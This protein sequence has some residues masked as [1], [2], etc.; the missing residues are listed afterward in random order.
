MRL[1]CFSSLNPKPSGISDYSEALLPH[2]ATR[3]STLDLFIEDYEPSAQFAC[4]NVRIRPWQEFEPEHRAG[5]YDAVLYHIG[6]NPFHVYIYDLAM[7]IPGVLVLH[8]FNLHYLVANAT[9]TRDDWEAYLREVEHSAGHAALERAREARAADLPLDY[10]TVALNRSLVERSQGAIVHSE[11]MVALLRGAG[12]HLPVRRIPHGVDIPSVDAAVARRCLAQRTGWSLDEKTSVIGIFGFLKPYKRIHESL[13]AFSR[14]RQHSPHI[15]MVLVGEEHPDYPLR[16]LIVDLKLDNDVRILGHVPI[17]EF[18]THMAA[19]D[20]CINLRRPTAGETS[21]SLLRALSLGKPTLISEIGSFL[22][23]PDGAAIRI[24]VDG[25]EESWIYEYLSVLLQDPELAQGI[26]ANGKAYVEQNCQWPKVAD[27]YVSFLDGCTRQSA[28]AGTANVGRENGFQTSARALPSA[29]DLAEYVVGFSHGSTLMEDYVLQHVKRLVRTLQVTPP[30]GP[31]DAVL[32]LGSYLQIT[33]GLKKYLGYGEVRGGYY[34]KIGEQK[35]RSTTSITGEEFT[36]PTDFFDCERDR[37][38]YPD[39][40]FKTVLCCELLEHLANDPMHMMAEINRIL[41]LGGW[42]V[43]TTPNITGFR[44]VYAVLRGYHPGL[45]PAYVKPSLDGSVNPR[46]SREYAPREI[47]L[48]AEAAGFH[49]ELLESGDYGGQDGDYVDTAAMLASTG[50]SNELR[51][52]VTYCVARKTG[53]VRDRW[54]K[55]IYYP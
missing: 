10:D 8:E 33:P 18:T 23:V 52:D 21:G 40:T 31:Q 37:F 34:G 13:H 28:S 15:K 49:V 43:L 50:F 16:P 20:I 48:L 38:P 55:E 29:A 27:D 47:A 9:I 6:N 2:L 3:I 36:C 25:R 1:A 53:P 26:G 32:E 39:G 11:Y 4:P 51:G 5:R 44:S 45:F 46:H 19:V 12:F 14:L 24:P 54:P 30:G 41:A 35:Q 17:A 22:E 7:R 42:L